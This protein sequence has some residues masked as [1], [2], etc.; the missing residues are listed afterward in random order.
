MNQQ[1]VFINTPSHE[2]SSPPVAGPWPVY[3]SF[4]GL[5]E[6]DRW[7]MYESAK[8]YRR[9]LEAHGFEMSETYDAF[10]RRVIDELEI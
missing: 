1:P 5:P 4:R 3:T 2:P 10:I 9:M 7:M 6:Q 8:A